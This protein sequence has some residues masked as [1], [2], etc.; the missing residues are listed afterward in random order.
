M[1]NKIREYRIK[2]I[3]SENLLDLR[4]AYNLEKDPATY[5]VVTAS[6]A[7]KIRARL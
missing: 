2:T 6:S 4:S 5:Q 7:N 1:P 3:S